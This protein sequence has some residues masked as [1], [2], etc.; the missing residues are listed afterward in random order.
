VVLGIV[1][2]TAMAVL[3]AADL[4]REWSQRMDEAYRHLAGLAR[5]LE[6]HA[7]RTVQGTDLLLVNVVESI[8]GADGRRNGDLVG[9]L[10]RSARLAPHVLMLVVLDR[11][12]RVMYGSGGGALRDDDL[13][14]CACFAAAQANPAHDGL[15]IDH[16]VASRPGIP[17]GTLTFTRPWRDADGG[18]SGAVV[19]F[20]DTGY[21]LHFYDSVRFGEYGVVVLL[22]DGGRLLVRAPPGRLVPGTDVS[23]HPVYRAMVESGRAALL[24]LEDPTIAEVDL[25]AQRALEAYPLRIAVSARRTE[26]QAGFY[27]H[28]RSSLIALVSITIAICLLIW[29]LMIHLR[30]HERTA[31]ALSV[32]KS[33]F[34]QLFD[35]SPEGIVILN[36]ED[37]IVDANRAFQQMFQYGVD[38]LR[39]RMLNEVILPEHLRSEA[40]ALSQRVLDEEAVHAEER[41]LCYV[42]MTRARDELV[43]TYAR[44]SESGRLRRPR[45]HAPDRRA[46]GEAA[47]SG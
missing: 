29:Y 25:V 9:F 31:Q 12:G 37:R 21:F 43:M 11:D 23:S 39:G 44:R 18:F 42:A 3:V 5:T 7:I 8:E 16:T 40:S 36:N 4:R 28:L 20:V 33:Y 10:D 34:Q 41:R 19:A 27:R 14:D 15:Y 17:S 38:E 6:E 1:V 2:V 22:R 13:A 32:Q 30:R 26:V 46:H 47:T 24:Q 35:G 45:S